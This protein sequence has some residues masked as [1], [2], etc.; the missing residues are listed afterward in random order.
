MIVAIN[1]LSVQTWP[2]TLLKVKDLLTLMCYRLIHTAGARVKHTQTAVLQS[3]L[4][5]NVLYWTYLHSCVTDLLTL[6]CYLP[7]FL[8]DL[9]KLLCYRYYCYALN[10]S[11]ARIPLLQGV[12]IRKNRDDSLC[13]GWL[14]MLMYR[15]YILTGFGHNMLLS[16]HK[17][18]MRT[19]PRETSRLPTKPRE[20]PRPPTKPLNCH[21]QFHYK[22]PEVSC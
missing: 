5:F 8:M 21:V 4:L 6:L 19:K 14:C 1:F 16:A 7:C 15:Y 10:L 20:A 13:Q 18:H 11:W 22:Y 2:M 3:Y 12:R 17:A 9:C